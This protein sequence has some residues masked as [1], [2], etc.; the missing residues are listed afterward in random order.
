[1]SFEIED[2]HPIPAAGQGSGR[3]EKYPWSQM[4]V[5]QSFFVENGE[6]RKIAGAACHSG[7][8]NGKKFVVRVVDGGVRAWRIE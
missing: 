8:R 1:M 7:R 6:V 2:D 3:K 4:D 5:G